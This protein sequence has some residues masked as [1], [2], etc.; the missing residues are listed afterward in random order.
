MLGSQISSTFLTLTTDHADECESG[1]W[2]LLVLIR[3]A[4]HMTAL[5]SKLTA[6]AL[7]K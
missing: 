3:P 7:R 6:K 1:R 4:S 5:E 2:R